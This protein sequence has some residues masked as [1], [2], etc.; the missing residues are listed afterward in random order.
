MRKRFN[1]GRGRTRQPLRTSTD[2]GVEL[3]D[4]G[5]SLASKRPY[6]PNEYSATAL[7]LIPAISLV[8]ILY[9]LFGLYLGDLRLPRKRGPDMEFHGFA[10]WLLFAAIVVGC[11]A[12]LSCVIDHYDRRDNEQ[13]YVLFKRMCIKIGVALFVSACIWRIAWPY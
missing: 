9:G 1:I 11:A 10:A 5:P 8:L 2:S 4:T 6:R 12:M 13:Y 7:V 3:R